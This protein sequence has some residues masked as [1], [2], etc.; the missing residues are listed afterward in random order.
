MGVISLTKDVLWRNKACDPSVARD[1][2]G[3]SGAGVLTQEGAPHR[4]AGI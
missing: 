2:R 1:E 4:W 3:W